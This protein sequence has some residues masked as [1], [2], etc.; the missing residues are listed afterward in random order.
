MRLKIVQDFRAVTINGSDHVT[1]IRRKR[2]NH[3]TA[4]LG[5]YYVLDSSYQ[6]AA[7]LEPALEDAAQDMHEF[8]YL[9]DSNTALM[10]STRVRQVSSETKPVVECLFHEINVDSREIVFE[11]ASLDHVPVS[12]TTFP[13]R[14]P[15]T[16][17]YL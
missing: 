8:R 16:L 17:D 13:G 2:D 6:V 3:K 11:W 7:Y 14:D 12:E 15:G 10:T 5:G 9:N 1:F 4:E